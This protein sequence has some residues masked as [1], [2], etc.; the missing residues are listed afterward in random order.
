MSPSA[1]DLTGIHRVEK[2]YLELLFRCNM[3][4]GICYHGEDLKRRDVL[5]HEQVRNA[6][7]YFAD[8]YGCRQA[9]F[10]G[11]EP[12]LYDEL[13]RVLAT[14]QQ[15]GYQTEVCTNGYRRRRVLEACVPHPDLLRISLDAGTREAHDA[16]RRPESFDAA[17][18]TMAW[19]A[20]RRLPFGATCT[21][22]A[23]HIGTIAELAARLR[24]TGAVE[25]QLHRLRPIGNAA[26][27][28]LQPVTWGQTRAL[29][30]Q[31]TRMDLG[32]MQ[33][34]LDILLPERCPQPT[35]HVE[36][37]EIAPD[38]RVYLS[39]AE[40]AGPGQNVRYD[41]DQAALVPVDPR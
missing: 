30:D 4:C 32:Q 27:S 39:C 21:L 3:S 25:L 36:K 40:V 34:N 20:G 1:S 13:P 41:F 33:V 38:G 37:L 14:A 2:L 6:L 5:T 31:L 18:D 7:I 12:L 19:A 16:I 24:D 29:H 8:R 35:G 10:L 28:G 15:L 23:Q 22:T 26:T 17:F 9:C 11:G